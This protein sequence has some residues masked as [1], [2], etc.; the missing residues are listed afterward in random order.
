MSINGRIRKLIN[1]F[2]EYYTSI[3]IQIPELCVLTQIYIKKLNGK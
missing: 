2:I 1:V 3:K